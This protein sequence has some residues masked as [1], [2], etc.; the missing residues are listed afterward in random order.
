MTARPL[1]PYS[2]Y[3][4]RWLRTKSNFELGFGY[5]KGERYGKLVLAYVDVPDVA[6]HETL[7][8]RE[9]VIDKPIASG[10]RV[11]L[12]GPVYGWDG[13]VIT[14]Q[15]TG[16]RYHVAPVNSGSPR[17]VS[18][19]ELKVRWNRPLAN[20]AVAVAYGMVEAPTFYEARS[21]LLDELIQQRQACRGLTAAIS[22]PIALFQHQ[23]DTAARI[24]ADP[25][26]RY[27]LA[28]EVGLGK[29]IEAGIVIRQL[30]VE[31]PRVKVL[32]LCP[33]NLCGQW[34]SEL[35]DRLA[36]GDALNSRTVTVVPH[37]EVDSCEARLKDGLCHF[38]LIVID[39]AHNF[40]KYL[41]PNSSI[42][43]QF[44]KADGLIA[45]SATPLRGDMETYRRLL[46]L[47]D[48][49]AF[50]GVSLPEFRNLIEERER[51]AVDVQV[52]ATRRASLRQKSAVLARLEADFP[53]DANI[54]AMVDQCRSAEDQAAP[55]WARLA[56]YVREIYR[57]SRRMIR[58]RRGGGLT[59]A[60]TVA[61]R[62]PTYVE[63][64]DP[65]RPI[66]DEFLELY[67]LQL[68]GSDAVDHYPEA[69]LRALAGPA[70][71]LPYLQESS[72]DTERGLFNMTAARLELAGADHRLRAAAE[73]VAD[74]VGKGLRVVVVS[75][76]SRV[77]SR[78]GEILSGEVDSLVIHWH[79]ASMAPEDRDSEVDMFI[80]GYRGSV[81]MADS[82][83]EEGRNLQAAEVLVNLDLPLDVNQLEQRI[84]RLDRYAVRPDPAEVVVFT[85]SGSEW[86]TSQ[87]ALLRDGI[88]VFDNS[89]ST[90]QRLLADVLAEIIAGLSL[91]G[92]EALQVD[93][94]RL[95]KDLDNEK[96]NIDLLEELESV[97]SASV[98]TDEIVD[99]LLDKESDSDNLRRCVR[100]F[101]TG[102]GSLALQAVEDHSGVVTFRNARNV[103]LS[104]EDA[105][106][107]EVLLKP[108]AF[109]RATA[110]EHSGVAPFRVGDPLVDW[111]QR[112]L[113][114]DERGRASAIAR[115]VSGLSAPE[116]W[117]HC[118]FLVEF[119]DDQF[120]IPKGSDRQRF[121]RRGETHLQPIRLDTWTDPSGSA[122]ASL[123]EKVLNLRF[124]RN[125]DAILRRESWGFILEEFPAWATLCERSATMAWREVEAVMRNSNALRDAIESAER[126]S[127][128]RLAILETRALRLTASSEHE[129]A[130][131]ELRSERIVAHA[132]VSGVENP[133]VRMVA[134]GACVLCPEEQFS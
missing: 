41:K 33:E 19:S 43:D 65:A 105:D 18:E 106:A 32:V 54:R 51:S 50:S 31:D 114:A 53:R 129:S 116:L 89:V 131:A 14:R 38:D 64:V 60:Y 21:G 128:R 120:E 87:L 113:V 103:G 45:L 75:A 122:P 119:N 7:V 49:L 111:L 10:T 69:V 25:A 95:R 70:A 56:D 99:E 90:V 42:E 78:F 92:V 40:L 133:K 132:L 8:D 15:L 107:L 121:A 48:P 79:L 134:C 127:S 63:V 11:W 84:G 81:L 20:P 58:H 27:L 71:I 39:E 100:N 68:E 104:K 72:R 110:I 66:L 2:H 88:G 62:T 126:D 3:I 97:E 125:R 93:I 76:F 73:I 12:R 44:I 67:R 108:K 118:E 5:C 80:R 1:R 91:N 112:Y 83:V 17:K 55:Q 130:E 117:L 37:S 36:L 86:V 22:A 77:L 82:S 61:G 26:M 6:E 98:F 47:V 29:T 123:V 109:D 24:L 96:Q 115:P 59:D 9:D 28:D 102:I 13:F 46:A 85:E 101:T 4:G 124:D 52:L 35:R 74:R 34:I 57:L 30:V 23:L 16:K 94:D